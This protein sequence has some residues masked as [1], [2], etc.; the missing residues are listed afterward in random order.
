VTPGIGWHLFG[1]QVSDNPSLVVVLVV[2]MSLTCDDS[3]IET[4]QFN[5]Q[6]HNLPL[7]RVNTTSYKLKLNNFVEI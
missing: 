2:V 3:L 7:E 1:P 6:P 4:G 5:D